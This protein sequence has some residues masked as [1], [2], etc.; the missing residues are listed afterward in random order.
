MLQN[1][2]FLNAWHLASFG[3][4]GRQHH[5]VQLAQKQ[6]VQPTSGPASLWLAST[7]LKTPC[8]QMQKGRVRLGGQGFVFPI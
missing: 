8:S 5:A 2:C 7:P 1:K 3:K 6:A 4:D